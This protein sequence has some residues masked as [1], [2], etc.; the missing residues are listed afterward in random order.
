MGGGSPRRAG[1]RVR[2]RGPVTRGDEGDGR[3]SAICPTP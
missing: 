3:I 2:A 1:H